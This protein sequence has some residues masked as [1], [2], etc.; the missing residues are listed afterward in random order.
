MRLYLSSFRFGN[1]IA[2]LRALVHG[3]RAAVI[4]NAL[5][6]I[7]QESRDD[8]ARRVFDPLAELERV[9][10]SVRPLDLRDYFGRAEQLASALSGLD[11]VWLEGG[12]TFL[13]AHAMQSSGCDRLITDMVRADRLVYGGCSAGAIIAGPNL[14]GIELMDDPDVVTKI[15]GVAASFDGLGLI[16]HMIVPHFESD[17]QD[18]VAAGRIALHWS[19]QKIGFEALRDGE[20]LLVSGGTRRFDRR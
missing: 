2:E 5:D 15:Y 10:F 14:H 11:F 16:D 3:D 7:S 20:T 13:L 1:Q 6:F 17:S 12:N 18:G 19:A 8:Y 4:A 9:G